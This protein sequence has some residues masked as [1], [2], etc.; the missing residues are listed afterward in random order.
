MKKDVSKGGL[1]TGQSRGNAATT[2]TGPVVCI[3]DSYRLS[4]RRQTGH[5]LE[6]D[7]RSIQAE[8]A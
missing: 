6:I 8:R 3:P 7:S 2:T 4:T 5:E 1:C